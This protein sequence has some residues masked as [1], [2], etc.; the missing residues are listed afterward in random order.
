M[1]EKQVRSTRKLQV[2][3]AVHTNTIGDRKELRASKGLNE[4]L[5]WEFRKQSILRMELE[6]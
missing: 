5:I 6:R 1:E 3:A 4:P 2:E